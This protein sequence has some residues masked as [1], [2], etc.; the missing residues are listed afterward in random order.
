MP[1]RPLDME[2]LPD[3]CGPLLV[4][5][6]DH[7]LGMIVAGAVLANTFDL[8]VARSI[9]EDVEG[10]FASGQMIRGSAADDYT[11]PFVC[12]LQEHRARQLRHLLAVE[13]VGTH[14]AALSA[15]APEET[16]NTGEERIGMLVEFLDGFHVH[17][18]HSGDVKDQT[19]VDELPIKT[20][21]QVGGDLHPSTPDFAVDGDV[22]NT[23]IQPRTGRC[24]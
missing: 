12:R 15:S 5:G 1:F 22:A 9:E 21:R 3:E 16:A 10:V 4:C 6:V 19:L 17:V 24:L 2:V 14:D 20:A 7:L 23:H 18:S 13:L 8:V 11:L